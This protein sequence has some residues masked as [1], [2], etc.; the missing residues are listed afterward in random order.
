VEGIVTEKVCIDRVLPKDL[1]RFQPTLQLAGRTSAISPIGKT[2][3]NGSTLRVRF[4][5]GTPEQHAIVREQ[6]GWWGQIANLKFD[7][8]NAP[9]AEIRISF[10]PNDG[11]WSYVGTDCRYI[12]A[13]Q[14]TMNIGFT[15][16]GTAAHEWGHALSLGHEHSNPLGG[17]VWNEPVVIEALS[18][19]PNFWSEEQI[20]HNVFRKY[21]VDQVNGTTFDPHSIMLYAFPVSWTLNGVS[22]KSNEVLSQMD[23]AF[24]SGALMYPKSGDTLEDA[25]E[26]R[27]NVRATTM[28]LRRYGEEDLFVFTVK[29]DGLHVVETSGPT[30]VV[31]KLFGPNSET[32]LIAEDDDSGI[33]GNARIAAS[34]VRGDYFVQVRHSNRTRGIGKYSIRVVTG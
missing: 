3:I 28:F 10:D 25:R 4:M 31:M 29:T 11:A 6:A 15:D 21:S 14:A 5:G 26:M 9:A 24:V 27:V 2:W 8:N 12:P 17:I 32:A 13:D 7:F 1:M 20:R 30:N 16:F 23:K 34:L 18:G 22:T 19:P 33:A